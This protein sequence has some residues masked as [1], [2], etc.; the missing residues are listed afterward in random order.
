MKNSVEKNLQMYFNV[1]VGR[2][3]IIQSTGMTEANYIRGYGGYKVQQMLQ[4]A[5][6]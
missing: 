6:R 2:N 4:G 3:C 1:Q 5:Y